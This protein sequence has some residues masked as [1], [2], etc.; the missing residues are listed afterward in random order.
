RLTEQLLSLAHAS[1]NDPTPHMPVDLAALAREVVLLYLPL[2]RE[3]QQDLG[4]LDTRADTKDR[5]AESVWVL[6]SDAE[7]HE[8]IANLVHNAIN[9]AGE[10]CS[11]T[12]SAGTDGE[13]AWV[14]VADNGVGLEPELRESVFSRFDRGARDRKGTGGGG[15]G[16]GLAIALAYAQRN[17][18]SITLIDGDPS[19]QGG[20]GLCATLKLPAYQPGAEA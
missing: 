8:S 7:L 2:A 5:G 9:H 1:R 3:K 19:P 13:H 20:V 11:I 14:S 18:G 4:W 17:R 6:G 15:S 10:G 16:L 12:V